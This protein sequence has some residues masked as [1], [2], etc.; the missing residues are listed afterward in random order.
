MA[1]Y[2]KDRWG[3]INGKMVLLDH[4][5]KLLLKNKGGE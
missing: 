1:E 3:E 4:Y 2:H 5:K